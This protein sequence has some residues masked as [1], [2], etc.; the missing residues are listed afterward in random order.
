MQRI[1]FTRLKILKSNLLFTTANTIISPF[2][3]LTGSLPLIVS[4]LSRLTD[5]FS[6]FVTHH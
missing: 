2:V 6:A 3:L 4:T 5:N 1:L